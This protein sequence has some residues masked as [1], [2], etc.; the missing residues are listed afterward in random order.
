MAIDMIQLLLAFGY[1]WMIVSCGL[2]FVQGV[3]HEQHLLLL[4]KMASAGDLSG[5]H[6]ELSEYKRKSTIHTHSMLFP[7]VAIVIALSLP[8][9]G[10]VGIYQS[11]LVLALIAATVIWTLGSLVKS[12]LAMGLG[13]SLLLISIATTFV[14]LLDSI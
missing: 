1:L 8:Q 2:G 4:E 3:K 13:D 11:A 9:A 6:Q 10:Y 12:R 7:L 5:Y 14:G